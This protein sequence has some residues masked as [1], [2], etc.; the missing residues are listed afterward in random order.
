MKA[1]NFFLFLTISVLYSLFG[2]SQKLPHRNLKGILSISSHQDVTILFSLNNDGF[3]EDLFYIPEQFVFGKKINSLEINEDTIIFKMKEIRSVYKGIINYDSLYIIGNWEQGGAKLPLKMYFKPDS[4][5]YSFNRPQEPQPPYPYVEQEI[6]V[7]HKKAKLTLSGTLTLP[8]T[9]SQYPLVVLITGS[10]PQDRNEELAGHKPFKVIADY[11]T[12]NG[13]AV[14][15]FDD[16]GVG[17]S[18]G[19]FGEATSE[20]FMQ[21]VLAI[22]RQLRK[23]RNIQKKSIGL[24]GHSEG[25]LI[26]MMAAAN[27]SKDIAFI[28]SLAGPGVHGR[29]ILEQQSYDI[30]KAAGVPDSVLNII[31]QFNSEMYDIF[32]SEKQSAQRNERIS[33]ILHT[34]SEKLSSKQRE[35]YGLTEHNI[36][37][38]SIQLSTSWMQFFLQSEP[39]KY[40]KRLRCPMLALNG[41]KDIQ[42]NAD[43]NLEAIQ[44]V[45]KNKKGQVYEIHKLEGLNHLFQTAEKGSVEEYLLIEETF[46]L[47]AMNIMK[48]F[49]KKISSGSL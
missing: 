34:Y 3:S 28:I 33:Q 11:L 4:L 23:H 32:L 6:E 10:G 8:D 18:T 43:I 7:L 45:L 44:D 15:R 20:D 9:I 30:N 41:A 29:K 31:K 13:I 22:V 37:L 42:V 27:N 2:Y 21:D 46:S 36:R 47:E 1:Y 17:K 39:A 12:R 19:N 48:N 26:A 5:F 35:Q 49:I 25:G 40:L 38:A 16:R 24:I 14:Y